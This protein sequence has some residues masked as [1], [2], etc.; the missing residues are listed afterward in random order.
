[1]YASAADLLTLFDAVEMST[2]ATPRRFGRAASADLLTATIDGAALDDWTE[3]EI[4]AADAALARIDEVLA[5]QH[6]LMDSYLGRRYALPLSA[7]TIAANPL[8]QV[9]ADLARYA[10]ATH[11]MPSE[12]VEERSKT[13]LN[14]LRDIAKGVAGLVQPDAVTGE[15]TANSG[16]SA[17]IGS[18]GSAYR[19][20]GY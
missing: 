5:E 2:H 8:R 16:F 19:W 6:R 4:A 14:W 12:D 18:P 3:D 9:C 13:A 10:M 1:M 20:E 17:R 11:A 7:A 15:S